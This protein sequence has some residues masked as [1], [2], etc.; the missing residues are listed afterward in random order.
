MGF[1]T[2]KLKRWI[3]LCAPAV[4]VFMG[5]NVTLAQKQPAAIEPSS[6]AWKAAEGKASDYVGQETCAGCHADQAKQFGKTVHAHAEKAEAKYGTG[7]ES[8]HGPGKKYMVKSTMEARDK[9]V[10]AGLVYPATESCKLCHNPES[11]NFKGFDEKAMV[12]KIA[13]PDPKVKH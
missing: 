11:P 1:G 7:C 9:S 5:H 10:A 2:G 6:V 13:H 4:A 12:A 8:C 3:W